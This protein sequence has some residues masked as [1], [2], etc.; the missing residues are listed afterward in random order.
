MNSV[1]QA[2]LPIF[3]LSVFVF[4]CAG[5][6]IFFGREAASSGS[7]KYI[8]THLD[9]FQYWGMADGASETPSSEAN[10]FYYEER[11]AA[12]SFAYPFV[13]LAGKAARLFGVSVLTFLPLWQIGMPFLIWLIAT[14]AISRFFEKDFLRVGLFVL[15]LMV[16]TL[17]L[18]GA[19]SFIFFRFS[20]PADGLFLMI[21]WLAWLARRF[22]ARDNRFSLLRWTPVLLVWF[23]PVYLLPGLLILVC[24]L[25]FTLRTRQ[26]GNG[27]VP[28]FFIILGALGLYGLYVYFRSGE[29]NWLLQHISID[30]NHALEHSMSGTHYSRMPDLLSLCFW[31]AAASWVL[32]RRNLKPLGLD[33]LFLGLLAVD[34]VL[35][36]VQI[37]LGANYQAELHRY[38]FL[39]PQ[40]LIL[41][42]WIGRE[43]FSLPAWVSGILGACGLAAAA[44]MTRSAS[45]NFLLLFP[46]D[47][48]FFF[49]FN[50]TRLLCGLTGIAF[51]V[52]AIIRFFISKRVLAAPPLFAVILIA[53]LAGYALRPSEMRVSNYAYPFEGSHA[54]LNQNAVPGDVVLNLSPARRWNQDYLIFYTGLRNYYHPYFGHVHARDKEANIYRSTFYNL[55]LLGK[56]DSIPIGDSRTLKEKLT[57]LRLNYILT[58]LPSPFIMR[59]ENELEGYLE[60]V[61]EDERSLLWRVKIPA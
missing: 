25:L 40:M 30:R 11:G 23:H 20:R 53:G 10:P 3:I 28:Q 56:L 43:S 14:R 42:Y 47:T 60:R 29:N 22:E 32:M 7:W 55:L 15:A 31:T 59:V 39:F 8:I 12:N 46:I 26:R 1:K 16:L 58:D 50:Q 54:W 5:F 13:S 38:Y 6:G 57:R 61:Y 4:F 49:S 41:F 24:E 44:A 2:S 34:P 19:A 51:A 48:P 21:P 9:G 45:W 33:I 52:S 37:L 36:N 17:Y 18:R 35:A 27:L